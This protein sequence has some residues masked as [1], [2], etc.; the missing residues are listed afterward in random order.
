[1]AKFAGRRDC[2]LAVIVL[3]V[4]PYPTE[5]WKRLEDNVQKNRGQT[6]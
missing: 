6:S 1:M 4:D 2:A 3:P 5:V